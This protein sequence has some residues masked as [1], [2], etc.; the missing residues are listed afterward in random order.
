M[1]TKTVK[2][3]KNNSL[4][5]QK[6]SQNDGRLAL[7]PGCFFA[8][9]YICVGMSRTVIIKIARNCALFRVEGYSKADC[10]WPLKTSTDCFKIHQ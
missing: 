10:H 8:L 5:N 3:K 6:K 9:M 2:E 4:N 1:A 7:H